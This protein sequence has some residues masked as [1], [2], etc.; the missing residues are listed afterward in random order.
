MVISELTF[1][2]PEA[3][4][5]VHDVQQG[6]KHKEQIVFAG[7]IGPVGKKIGARLYSK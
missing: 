3:L 7:R 2:D 4:S 1:G 6:I 5:S